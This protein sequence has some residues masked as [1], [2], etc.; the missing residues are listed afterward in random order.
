MRVFVTG[1][2][3]FIGRCV[4]NELRGRDHEVLLLSR[5]RQSAR[6]KIRGVFVL[7]GD[8]AGIAG[9][10]DEVKKFQ[11]QAA[12]HLAWE[13]LPDYSVSPS[14]KN[15][16]YGLDLVTLLAE[17]GCGSIIGTGSCWEYGRQTGELNEEMVPQPNNAFTAAKDAL[18]QL[19]GE[20]AREHGTNF[21]WTRLFYV[22]GP[23]QR[24]ASLIPHI[25][26]SVKEGKNPA[27]K[28]PAARNDF[29]YVEDVARAIT[30]IIER[31]LASGVYNIGSGLATGV[32]RIVEIA[33]R[34]LA[35]PCENGGPDAPP[36]SHAVDFWAD[37][38]RIKRDTGWE[39]ETG[40][41]DGIAKTIEYYQTTK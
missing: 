26:G 22:Y 31:Q 20:I 27:L 12:V 10:A 39:P 3:G 11:P 19:G 32:R 37:I 9:W 24:E 36:D 29:V 38:A 15:L 7:P 14:I 28:A 25:I 8:L 13:G 35:F 41:E 40:I 5:R 2:T 17:A 6:E 34:K 30:A 4:V 1:G 21:I 33:C 23:G 18:R 16:D